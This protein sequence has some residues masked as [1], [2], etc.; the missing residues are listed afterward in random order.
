VTEV[1]MKKAIV[2][3]RISYW[4]G[5]ILDGLN[6]VP[7]LFP[8][9]G[10][11]MFG[12]SG[13]NPGAE[14]RYVSYIGAALMLGWTVLLIWADRR[15]VERKGIILITV[16]PVILGISIA[17]VYALSAGVFPAS[18]LAPLFILQCALTALFLFSFFYARHEEKRAA[19]SR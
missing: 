4:A 14:Y 19:N 11:N 9:I 1:D 12:L 16:V 10:G 18:R 7:L 15:P 8:E 17:G 2:L 5:A 3:L 13:F 6:V